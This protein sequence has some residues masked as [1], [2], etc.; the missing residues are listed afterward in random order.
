MTLQ[1]AKVQCSSLAHTQGSGKPRL[2]DFSN[3]GAYEETLKIHHQLA[4]KNRNIY[5]SDEDRARAFDVDFQAY[6]SKPVS[7]QVLVEA[8]AGI[9]N[10]PNN[11][12]N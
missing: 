9:I 2:R 7:L 3:R 8:I 4:I 12:A 1:A 5:L 11:L 10:M 6:L